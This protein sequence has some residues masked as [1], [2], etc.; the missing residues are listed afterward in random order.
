MKILPVVE[1]QKLTKTTPN[2]TKKV[3]GWLSWVGGLSSIFLC[4]LCCSLP[5]V[6]I[7][8]VGGGTILAGLEAIFKLSSWL[9]LVL[10]LV[11]LSLVVA[12]TWVWRKRV[13]SSSSKPNLTT[14]TCS[15]SCTT[16]H[17]CNC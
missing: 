1:S 11:A 10:A 6:G 7:V 16:D 17:T 8:T 9:W 13:N 12:T 5:L 15:Q 14:H 4:G 2:T 3:S